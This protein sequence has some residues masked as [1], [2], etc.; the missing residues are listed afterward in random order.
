MDA[1]LRTHPIIMIAAVAL[2]LTCLL[3]IGVMTGIVP[4]PLTKHTAQTRDLSMA[5][6][7][8][9]QTESS[10]NRYAPSG[11]VVAPQTRLADPAPTASKS[12]SAGSSTARAPVT[13][14]GP[15]PATGTTESRAPTNTVSAAPA[16]APC[17]SC[18]TVSAVRAVKQQGEASMIGPAAGA[19]IGGVVG[20]QIGSGRGNTIATV[21]G[22][23]GGAAAGTEIERRAKSTTHYDVAVRMND[24]TV[25]HFNY[26]AAPGV[27]SG[28]RVRVVD[29]RLVHD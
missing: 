13:S 15:L 19:L 12:A 17:R 14:S 23:G 6:G 4:S 20:H 18:G 3:A 28:D 25:R 21:I 10:L 9:P 26:A 7:T 1:N 22:A 24:G 2:I 11:P 27:H 16:P 8:S 29:G 5:P